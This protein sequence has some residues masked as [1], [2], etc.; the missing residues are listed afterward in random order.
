MGN[1]IDL[2]NKRFGKLIVVEEAERKKDN[3]ILWKCQCDCGN[4]AIIRGDCLRDGFSQSC[5]CLMR[6]RSSKANKT[7]G[8][9]KTPEYK[10]WVGI[11]QRCNNPKEPNYKNY[12]IRG[13]EVC[14]RWLKFEN[15]FED[16]GKKPEG[17]TIER[18]NNNL[19]YFK[20]NCVWATCTQ[21]LRNQRIQKRNKTGIRGV[22][23]NKQ[24][25]RYVVRIAANGKNYYMGSFLDLEIA[26]EARKQAEQEYW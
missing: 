26:A 8:M 11:K 5:G 6:E 2:I 21:Q 12:G 3:K 7:H 14:T 22:F 13:I 4:I 10:T 9:H 20:E 19:G 24:D 25:N 18:T 1:K 17:L 15:F 23:W 16:M